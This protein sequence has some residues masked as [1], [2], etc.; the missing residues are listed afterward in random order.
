MQ[1]QA[2][3]IVLESTMCAIAVLALNVF[4]PG[5]MFQQSKKTSKVESEGSDLQ[6]V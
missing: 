6:G 3:F 4:H 5:F 2:S 1:D